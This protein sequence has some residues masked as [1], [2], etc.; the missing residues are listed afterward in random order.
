MSDRDEWDLPDDAA[1]PDEAGDALD[2]EEFSLDDSVADLV[3]DVQCPYCGESVEI[4]LDPGSGTLAGVS[5]LHPLL[6][7]LLAI[8][9]IEQIVAYAASYH[10]PARRPA[11]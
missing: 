6:Y 1:D 3:G 5:L 10:L 11:A 8:L 2:D 9:V 4:P 7:A